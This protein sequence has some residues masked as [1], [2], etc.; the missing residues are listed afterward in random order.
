MMECDE[1]IFSIHAVQRMY[2]RK[3]SDEEIID[4]VVTGEII[5]EYP[6]D[7]P[8]PSRLLLGHVAGRALHVV[9]AI[10]PGTKKCYI[11][12]V[13]VPDPDTWNEGFRTRRK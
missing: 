8:L 7:Y 10:E 6:D 9:A 11:I 3:I 13:Y 12:T 5:E 1:Y 2:R 4:V